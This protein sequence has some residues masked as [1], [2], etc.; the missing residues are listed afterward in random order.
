MFNP[1]HE[2]HILEISTDI[3]R[4]INVWQAR[5]NLFGGKNL[6]DFLDQCIHAC[7]PETQ[8]TDLIE[9]YEL[10]LAT[11][12]IFRYLKLRKITI[13]DEDEEKYLVA[14]KLKKIFFDPIRNGIALIMAELKMHRREIVGSNKKSPPASPS[15]SSKTTVSTTKSMCQTKNKNTK[16]K[17]KAN[18]QQKHNPVNDSTSTSGPI[19]A[20]D[21]SIKAAQPVA[22]HNL[23]L[24]SCSEVVD[25]NL[26]GP[27]EQFETSLR[28]L[29][30]KQDE[31]DCINWVMCRIDLVESVLVRTCDLYNC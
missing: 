17:T 6:V 26:M 2:A 7:L 5:Y 9:N 10:L 24:E 27:D 25:P 22:T 20:Q 11:L 1:S 12:T 31:V 30:S 18:N 21:L 19:T 3:M 13:K 8:H 28:S 23:S 29:K 16:R 15:A 4:R 14:K